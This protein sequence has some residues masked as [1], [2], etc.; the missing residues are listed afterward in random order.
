VGYFAPPTKSL[1][2]FRGP[3]KPP[4]IGLLARIYGVKN[5]YASLIRAYAAYHITNPQVYD[6]AMC[7]FVG[8]LFLYATETF[9]YRTV[10]PKGAI[11]PFVTAGGGLAWMWAQRGWYLA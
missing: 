6:L 1:I 4:P 3:E 10:E 7:T 2:Q 9:V 8:V 5:I 11:F